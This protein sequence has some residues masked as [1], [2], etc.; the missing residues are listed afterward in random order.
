[1]KRNN[2]S[3]LLIDEDDEKHRIPVEQAEAIYSHGQI[4]INTRLSDFLNKKGVEIHMFGWNGQYAGSLIPKSGQVSGETVVKQ[5]GAYNDDLHRRQ[6]ASEIVHA[7]ID[8]LVSSLKYYQRNGENSYQEQITKMNESISKLHTSTAINEIM[9]CEAEARASYYDVFREE[10]DNLD[11]KNRKYN[12]PQNEINATISYLNSLLYANCI[13]AIRKTALQPS[14]SYLH[15][16]GERRYSLALDIADLFKPLIVTRNTIRMFNRG[17]LTEDD[18][19]DELNG[20][21]L[22]DD[23]QESCNREMEKQLDKTIEHR[24]LNRHVSYHYL[25]QLESYKMKKHLIAREE[26]NAFRKWW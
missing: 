10:I 17:Q 7:S 2:D 4:D 18:F 19:T 1:M 8:S 6:I 16:P 26:Y 5:V 20:V 9:G 25:L 14:V 21:L 3:L 15:E 24:E 22:N 23:G 11:F 12:P 13:S